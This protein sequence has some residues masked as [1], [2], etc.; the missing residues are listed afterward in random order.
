MA[1]IPVHDEQ[2]SRDRPYDLTV[3]FAREAI[4]AVLT[5]LG[6]APWAGPRPE[7]LAVVAVENGDTSFVLA[8][9]GD[10][11]RDMR[12]AMV[13]AAEQYGI[14]VT[15]PTEAELATAGIAVSDVAGVNPAT[16]DALAREGGADDTVA[17]AL[18]WSDTDLG[19]DADWRMTADGVPYRWRAHRV[20]FDDAFRSA[21]G[22][23]ARILSGHGAPN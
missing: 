23:A 2:G 20:S 15:L 16:L 10:K 7:L 6:S 19:W 4:D 14:P 11:G 13:A 21:I 8:S 17:G 5:T 22:G 9:D 3:T 18:T 12:E 1:G